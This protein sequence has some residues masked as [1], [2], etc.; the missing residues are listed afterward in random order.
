LDDYDIKILTGER[1]KR[2]LRTLLRKK[3][4][5]FKGY[6]R[7]WGEGLWINDKYAAQLDLSAI[8]PSEQYNE[9]PE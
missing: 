4:Y 5:T 6:L 8:P 2:D 9:P 7:D 1:L 3:G